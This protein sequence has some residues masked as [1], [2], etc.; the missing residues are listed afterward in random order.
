MLARPSGMWL[1]LTVQLKAEQNVTI[2]R[3]EDGQIVAQVR[4]G[5]CSCV[6]GTNPAVGCGVVL[7][8]IECRSWLWLCVPRWACQPPRRLASGRLP[9]AGAGTCGLC[10]GSLRRGRCR[11]TC[12]CSSST[13][14]H[15]RLN[16]QNAMVCCIASAAVQVLC[17]CADI[18]VARPSLRAVVSAEHL[19]RE[20]RSRPHS[21]D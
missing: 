6:V 7:C 17:R 9:A 13:H 19:N 14:R 16:R 18:S 3:K 12:R 15:V 2:S 20:L 1:V 21:L 4:W 11:M 5:C 10:A 8:G